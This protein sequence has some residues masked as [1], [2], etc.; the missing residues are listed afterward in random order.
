MRALAA[1]AARL[2]MAGGEGPQSKRRGAMEEGREAGGRGTD[3]VT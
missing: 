3:H 2:E 1:L